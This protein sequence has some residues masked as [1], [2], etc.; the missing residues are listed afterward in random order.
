MYLM[1]LRAP[2]RLVSGIMCYYVSALPGKMIVGRACM[3]WSGIAEVFSVF[4]V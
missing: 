4:V 2:F 1:T 3:I